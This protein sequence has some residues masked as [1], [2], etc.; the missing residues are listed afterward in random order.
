MWCAA[1]RIS[2]R[3]FDLFLAMLW[4][5]RECQK[6]TCARQW[7]WNSMA[8]SN[9]RNH[10]GALTWI[11]HIGCYYDPHVCFWWQS[12][13]NSNHK[14]IYYRKLRTSLLS[15]CSQGN[16]EP[17]PKWNKKPRPFKSRTMML[18]IFIC[19]LVLIISFALNEMDGGWEIAGMAMA[20][21]LAYIRKS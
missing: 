16:W 6:P 12:D 1:W 18:L 17:S 5:A 4:I 11:H 9:G 14:I 7:L 20:W 2:L 3:Q 10:A 8:T 21:L 15:V 13:H 19:R